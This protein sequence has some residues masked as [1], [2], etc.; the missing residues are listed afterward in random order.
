M[1]YYQWLLR[2]QEI[3]PKPDRM[4]MLIRSRRSLGVAEDEV[5]AMADMPK[6]LVDELLQ[7]MV[8]AG[9]IHVRMRDGKRWFVTN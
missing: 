4:L 3:F 8:S 7:S 6:D 2:R 9:H 1:D 5:R